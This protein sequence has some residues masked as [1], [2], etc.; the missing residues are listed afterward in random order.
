MGKALNK[1]DVFGGTSARQVDAPT[2]PLTKQLFSLW[3]SKC[4]ADDMPLRHEMD[5]ASLQSMMPY[6]YIV[7]ILDDGADFCMRF[8]GS[9]IVQSI[10]RD[11]TGVKA[12]ENKDAESNWR[13]LVYRSVYEARKPMFTRVPLSDFERSH[14]MTECALLPLA[15]RHGDFSMIMCCATPLQ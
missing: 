11:Y 3:Q 7:D 4:G 14:V 15:N 6:I 1:N 2:A 13:A 12:S 10:G 5:A 8:M 9:A